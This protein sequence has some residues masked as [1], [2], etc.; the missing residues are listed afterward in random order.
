MKINKRNKKTKETKK[1]I[2]KKNLSKKIP[3]YI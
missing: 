1:Q 2:N 3:K